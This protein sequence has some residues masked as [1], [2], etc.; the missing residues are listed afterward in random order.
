MTHHGPGRRGEGEQ[1][2]RGKGLL[3]FQNRGERGRN[4]SLSI[5][6]NQSLLTC[7]KK[8]KGG[9]LCYPGDGRKTNGILEIKKADFAGSPGLKWE[10]T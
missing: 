9:V 3:Y 1:E 4:N 10:A 2:K 8:K 5:P 6:T 7:A